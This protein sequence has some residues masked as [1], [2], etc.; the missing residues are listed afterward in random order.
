ML[1]RSEVFYDLLSDKEFREIVNNSSG[2]H[3]IHPVIYLLDDDMVDYAKYNLYTRENTR[4]A[5]SFLKKNN[6]NWLKKSIKRL[7][8]KDM[9]NV[10]A[11]L[12][13]IRCFGCL[14]EVFGSENVRNI[15]EK[16]EPTPDFEVEFDGKNVMVEV[17]TIQ[18]NSVERTRIKKYY[19]AFFED[20]RNSIGECSYLPYG[21]K[22]G[23]SSHQSVILKVM[24][25]KEKNHQLK[26]DIPSILWIDLQDEIMNQLSDRICK[27]GPLFSGRNYSGTNGIYSNELWYSL[28]GKEGDFVFKGEALNRCE[29]MKVTLEKL[30]HSGKFCDDNKYENL[31]AV[32]YSGPNSLA[33]YENPYAKNKL[34][35]SFISMF[36]S[37]RWFKLEASVLSL[38]DEDLKERIEKSRKQ[39]YELSLKELY[40]F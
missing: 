16:K 26:Y 28:Y 39:I 35:D 15:E 13:E 34:P 37:A 7:T 6:I 25:V 19:E 12:G 20:G 27:S 30:V 32:V 4:S 33:L 1:K 3:F 29:G 38:V 11:T 9:A 14:A 17:N 22:P 2:E 23:V 5:I 36:T 24:S 10:S 18:M 31:S 40:S 8:D 21:E